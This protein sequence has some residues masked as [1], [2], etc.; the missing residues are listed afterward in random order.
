MLPHFLDQYLRAKYNYWAEVDRGEGEEPVC[1]A[2][3]VTNLQVSGEEPR[4]PAAG[5]EKGHRGSQIRDDPPE[6]RVGEQAEKGGHHRGI[7]RGRLA[8]RERKRPLQEYAFWGQ[9]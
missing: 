2:K 5:A 8:G 1:E 6:N 7:G 3:K 9:T 4:I